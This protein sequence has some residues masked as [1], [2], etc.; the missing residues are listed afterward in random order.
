MFFW[1]LWQASIGNKKIIELEQKSEMIWE[2]DVKN[3]IVFFN[4]TNG[5]WIIGCI[6]KLWIIDNFK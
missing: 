1:Y 4:E 6:V 3:K 5:I 2:W